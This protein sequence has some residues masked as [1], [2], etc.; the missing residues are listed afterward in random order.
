MFHSTLPNLAENFTGT[1]Y[2]GIILSKG[3][4]KQYE[5]VG[6]KFA[7]L[8]FSSSSSDKNNFLMVVNP[9]LTMRQNVI[10]LLEGSKTYPL[11]HLNLN[12]STLVGSF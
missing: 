5:K 11:T 9:S 4:V 8:S 6:T 1:T 12:T 7:W 2:R 10:G 3:Q